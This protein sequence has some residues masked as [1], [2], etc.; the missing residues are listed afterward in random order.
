MH[1]WYYS[2]EIVEF[3]KEKAIFDSVI[4]YICCYSGKV[5]EHFTHNETPWLAAR[6]NLPITAPSERIITKESIH[7]YFSAVKEKYNMVT[8]NDI[9]TYAQDM[10]RSLQNKYKEGQHEK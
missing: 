10:F 1:F 2:I 9:R 5:L 4:K 3:G 7:E 8:P 6:S